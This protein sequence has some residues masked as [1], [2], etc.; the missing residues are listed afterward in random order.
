MAAES[1]KRQIY[2]INLDLILQQLNISM[3]QF[4]D[5]CILCGCDYCDTLKGDGPST[6][7]RLMVQHGTL[8]K[9]LESLDADKIPAN[10]RYQV[11]REFFRECEAVDTGSITFEWRE[12]DLDGLR[13][14][15]IE[16]NSF[17]KDRVERFL[18]R[19]TNAKSRTKQC[20]LDSFFG[21][22]KVVI[23]DNEKFGP[24]KRKASAKA[25]AGDAKRQKR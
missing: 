3:D 23:K 11:A 14:F 16:E 20:P 19:L 18:E 17:S 4:I 6:A 21:A 5:F 22:P 7:I 12:P 8:E 2:E 9:V 13:R 1:Q 10:F 25:K 15:L 24:T